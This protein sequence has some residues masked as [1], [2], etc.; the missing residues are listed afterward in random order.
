M[1]IDEMD[2][3]TCWDLWGKINR[4]PVKTAR[5][6]FPHQP[7]RY[8]AVTKLIGAYLANKGTV[9]G[10]LEPDKKERRDVYIKIAAKIYCDIPHWGRSFSIF[11]A[12]LAV[13][14]EDK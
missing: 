5:A 13:K 8:V 11:R 4:N 14:I 2:Y 6:I 9:L 12:D 10:L 7:P 3:K 1:F